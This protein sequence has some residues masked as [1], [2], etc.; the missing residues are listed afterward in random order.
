MDDIFQKI[1]SKLTLSQRIERTIEKAIREKKLVA[2]DKLPTDQILA[3]INIQDA[4]GATKLMQDHLIR[5]REIYNRYM[6]NN[7]A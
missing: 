7:H 3:A 1:G 6:K 2:G 5:T 4:S